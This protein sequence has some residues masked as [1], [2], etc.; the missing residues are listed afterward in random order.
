MKSRKIISV[1]I[2][3]L[4]NNSN[5]LSKNETMMVFHGACPLG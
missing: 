5:L 3:F 4:G 2:K 1:K